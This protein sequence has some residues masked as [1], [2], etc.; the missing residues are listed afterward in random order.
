MVR[1]AG[2]IPALAAEGA[3]CFTGAF[4]WLASSV[5]FGAVLAAY[6]CGF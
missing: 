4:F 6:F 5:L 3:G 2:S 1:I